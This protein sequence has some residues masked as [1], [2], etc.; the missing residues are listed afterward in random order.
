VVVVRVAAL[1]KK[2]MSSPMTLGS[3]VVLGGKPSNLGIGKNGVRGGFLKTGQKPGRLS[4]SQRRSRV[5]HVLMI[6][7]LLTASRTLLMFWKNRA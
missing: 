4:H 3:D 6:S 7:K 5:D 2:Q 1:N